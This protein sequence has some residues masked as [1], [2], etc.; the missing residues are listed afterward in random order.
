MNPDTP[1]IDTPEIQNMARRG[2]DRCRDTDKKY[3]RD[4][5]QGKITFR[6]RNEFIYPFVALLSPVDQAIAVMNIESVANL[7]GSRNQKRI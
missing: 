5:I 1:Q 7:L 3:K 4:S 2:R 6:G